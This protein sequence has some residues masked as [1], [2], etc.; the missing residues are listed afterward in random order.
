LIEKSHEKFEKG[1]VMWRK[2]Y[3]PAFLDL[4]KYYVE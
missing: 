3:E 2:K 1:T 4:K